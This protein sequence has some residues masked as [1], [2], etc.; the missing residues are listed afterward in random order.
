MQKHQ[1]A[2]GSDTF[3]PLG[4]ALD[5]VMRLKFAIRRWHKAANLVVASNSAMKPGWSKINRLTDVELMCQSCVLHVKFESVSPGF[6]RIAGLTSSINRLKH[7]LYA[8]S[9]RG[10]SKC[11][12]KNNLILADGFYVTNWIAQTR[13]YIS[14]VQTRKPDR[15]PGPKICVRGTSAA[16]RPW[17]MRMRPLRTSLLRGSNA[18]QRPPR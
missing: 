16:S 7:L 2:F 13:G 6:N 10:N 5:P 17:A 18:C 4:N 3:V 11:T 1:I 15:T 14:S 9:L 8:N 12:S